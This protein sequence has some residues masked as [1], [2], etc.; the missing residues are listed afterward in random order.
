[1]HFC[2]DWSFSNFDWNQARAFLVTAE[3]GSL[4]SAAQALRTTQPTV[5]RQV[6]ALEAA[7]GVTLFN[8]TGRALT[9]TD[10][11]VELLDHV[12]AMGEAARDISLT[13]TG[14]SQAIEGHVTITAGDIVSVY[15]LPQVMR[16][17]REIAPGITIEIV[18]SNEVQDL[19]KRE[20]DIAIRHVRPTQ[21][22][23]IAKKVRTVDGRLYATPAYLERYGHPKALD[24]LDGA[25]FTGF[26]PLPRFLDEIRKTGLDL[27]R[28]HMPITSANSIVL[29][30][31]V[32]RGEAIGILSSDMAALIP[33]AQVVL[34]VFPAIPVDTWLVSHREL[35]TSRRIRLVFDVLAD[36]LMRPSLTDDLL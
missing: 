26:E 29:L 25:V 20:A 27:R 36:A 23:L 15:F 19:R 9:L 34:D 13:A 17:L 18:S 10:T 22:D 28:E 16:K 14:Q 4:S 2:M 32:R 30:E 12:R 21:P 35:L 1:M 11:G 31:M 7:L 8:R 33:D 3:E 6:A 5:G 24:D